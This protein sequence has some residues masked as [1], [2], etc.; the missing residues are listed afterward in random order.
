LYITGN[1]A[2]TVNHNNVT[3]RQCFLQTTPANSDSSVTVHVGPGTTG[4]VV[5][6]C[7][8]DGQ[9]TT[10]DT[11][12]VS[13]IDTWAI[14]NVTVRRCNF[15]RYGQ[16]IRFTLNNINFIENYCHQ[17]AGADSDYIECYPNGGAINNLLIQYNYLT[18]P[19]DSVQGGDSAINM[20]TGSGLP[21]GNIGP[22][23][24]ID[25]NWM[26]RTEA[27]Q[28][29]AWQ[30]HFIC[31]DRSSGG[32]L[33]FTLTNNGFYSAKAGAVWWSTTDGT[34][35]ESGNYVMSSPTS[36]TGTPIA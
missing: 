29:D 31:N 30:Y 24:I 28:A 27:T 13:N 33:E 36:R 7:Y 14:S 32:A 4:T 3:I 16:C 6:D 9:G 8:L 21:V 1:P 18:G 22:N 15:Y 10:N 2:V 12:G 17:C 35:H 19:D 25:S 20:T 11:N 23:I 26:V 5:E 34:I